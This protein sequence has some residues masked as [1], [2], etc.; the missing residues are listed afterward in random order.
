MNPGVD[1]QMDDYKGYSEK[2]D[3]EYSKKKTETYQ[4]KIM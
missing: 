2:D 3:H 4:T 1:P